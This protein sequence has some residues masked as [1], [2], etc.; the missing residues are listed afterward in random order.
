MDALI[1]RTLAEERE[2]TDDDNDTLVGKV[3]KRLAKGRNPQSGAEVGEARDGHN[4][5]IFPGWRK[6]PDDLVVMM[7]SSPLVS[8]FFVCTPF[9]ILTTSVLFFCGQVG[10]LRLVELKFTL[11]RGL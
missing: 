10:I 2:G 6:R 3:A 9:R 4:S 8:I 11:E 7:S 5:V 1:R